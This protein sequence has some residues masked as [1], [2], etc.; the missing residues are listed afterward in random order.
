[1]G[2]QRV[3]RPQPGPFDHQLYA[4]A[5]QT[6]F[7]PAALAAIQQEEQRL[8]R[9][10][11]HPERARVAMAVEAASPPRHWTWASSSTIWARRGTTCSKT[12][13]GTWG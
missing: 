6:S 8:G 5:N 12:S 7:S 1:M 4:N 2:G 9:P 10:L 13:A 11:S 3:H